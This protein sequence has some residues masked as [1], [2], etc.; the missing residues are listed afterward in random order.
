M[1]IAGIPWWTTDIGGFHGADIHDPEFKKLLIRWFEWSTFCPVM[2]LHGF[3][4]P[5]VGLDV[6]LIS[7]VGKLG[8]GAENEIWTYGAEAQKIMEKYIRLRESM[9]PYIREIMKE[10]SE[11]GTPVMRPLFYDFYTD[12]NAWNVDDEYMFGNDLLVAPIYQ[13]VVERNVYLPCGAT[14]M[15]IF[16]NLT[17]EGGQ[18]IS[19]HADMDKIPV[20]SRNGVKVFN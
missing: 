14:W 15:D 20:F 8:S 9:R 19:V 5:Q 16:S 17:Y 18:T 1:A 6:D 11:K 2:R 4:N 12:K 13:D 3:R 10:T 7:G